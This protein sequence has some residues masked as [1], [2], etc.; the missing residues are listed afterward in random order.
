MFSTEASESTHLGIVD[1]C[2]LSEGETLSLAV[3][4]DCGRWEKQAQQ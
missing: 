3:Q 2:L 1:F 4:V